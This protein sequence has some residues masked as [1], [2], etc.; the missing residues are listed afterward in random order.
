MVCEKTLGVPRNAGMDRRE[1]DG[2]D[3]GR[4]VSLNDPP[5]IA[6]QT[7]HNVKLANQLTSQTTFFFRWGAAVPAYD[8]SNQTVYLGPML[9]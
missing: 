4:S 6:S 2:R 5:P 1:C 8:S 9:R 3:P 7:Y